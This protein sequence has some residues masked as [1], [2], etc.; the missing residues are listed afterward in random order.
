MHLLAILVALLSSSVRQAPAPP[1]APPAAPAGSATEPLV[2]ER[3]I[4]APIEELWRVFSTGE[5]FTKLGPAQ[6]E[7]DLRLGGRIRT[8][9]DPQGVLGDDGTIENEILAFEAP[10]MIAFRI[11]KA[12]KGFPF[13]EAKESTWTVVTLTDV[14]AGRTHA[15]IAMLGWTGDAESQAM[16]AFFASG[17]EW[18]LQKLASAWDASA[19]PKAEARAHAEDPLAPVALEAVVAAPRSDVWRAWTTPAGWKDF[20]GAE[21]KIGARPLEELEILFFPSAPPGQR[22]AEGC[23]VL[24]F[25]PE[26][27]FSFTWSAPSKFPRARAERTWVVVELDALSPATTRVRLRHLGFAEL[28]AAHPED[29]KEWWEVRAYFTQAWPR[30]LGAL[31]ERFAP[32]RAASR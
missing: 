32:Q 27:M 22:G 15:R 16:R 31:T 14:G 6:A 19:A 4:E 17:N 11:A 2:R 28:A 29:A 18:T 26:Q 12:P 23:Q 25:V 21:A 7:V 24:S 8:H 13:P 1:P 9:Y 20:F 3:V 5:G 30:V 10:R